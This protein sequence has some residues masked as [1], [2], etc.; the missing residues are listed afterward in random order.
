ML[1]PWDLERRPRV[2]ASFR[3]S[4]IQDGNDTIR[5]GFPSLRFSAPFSY[6]WLPPCGGGKGCRN[7]R[8]FSVQDQGQWERASPWYSQQEFPCLSLPFPEPIHR[9]SQRNGMPWGSQTQMA[10]QPKSHGGSAPRI[11]QILEDRLVVVRRENR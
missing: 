10:C 8:V 3:L 4:W 2:E 6:G 7:S 5:I 11:S 1:A 9:G